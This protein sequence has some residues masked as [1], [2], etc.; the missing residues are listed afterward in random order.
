MIGMVMLICAGMAAFGGI[1]YCACNGETE[2]KVYLLYTL[3]PA[4]FGAISA[5]IFL[6]ALNF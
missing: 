2:I 4:F 3:I 5:L 6:N 1:M